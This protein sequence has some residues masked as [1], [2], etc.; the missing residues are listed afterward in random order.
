MY[1]EPSG[2]CSSVEPVLIPRGSADERELHRAALANVEHRREFGSACDVGRAGCALGAP[3][4][5]MVATPT[6]QQRLMRDLL[7]ISTV[8]LSQRS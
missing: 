6:G 3:E 5:S 8:A 2:T 4:G 1:M 7:V